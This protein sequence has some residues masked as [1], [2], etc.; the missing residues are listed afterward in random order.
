MLM[1]VLI[2]RQAE[3]IAVMRSSRSMVDFAGNDEAA[4]GRR[5]LKRAGR[6]QKMLIVLSKLSD[7]DARE[8]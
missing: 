6:R 1:L 5:Y 4:G 3:D 8:I 7:T 2:E